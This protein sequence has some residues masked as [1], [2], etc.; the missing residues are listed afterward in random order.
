MGEPRT[1]DQLA[2]GF[3]EIE[4]WADRTRARRWT[5]AGRLSL[6]FY[7]LMRRLR[8]AILV[9]VGCGVLLLSSGTAPARVGGGA[10][11]T[12][13][14]RAAAAGSAAFTADVVGEVGASGQDG[15][16]NSTC[17]LDAD[18]IVPATG[19]FPNS[20]DGRVQS[21]VAVSVTTSVNTAFPGCSQSGA[22]GPWHGQ[23]MEQSR[24]GGPNV[25][26]VT[27]ADFGALASGATVTRTLPSFSPAAGAGEFEAV[28]V[29]TGA[30]VQ[31]AQFHFVGEDV[32]PTPDVVARA[33][34]SGDPGTVEVLL[35]VRSSAAGSAACT[36]R[37]R[38]GDRVVPLIRVGTKATGSVRLSD[39]NAVCTDSETV[40]VLSGALTVQRAVRVP[41][42]H[43]A[44]AAAQAVRQSNGTI[45]TT[46]RVD[47]LLPTAKC[48]RPTASVRDSLA[49]FDMPLTQI[50]GPGARTGS[51]TA[52]RSIPPTTAFCISTLGYT[53]T[54]DQATARA[55]RPVTGAPCTLAP[56]TP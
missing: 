36:L 56:K 49:S 20:P 44:F 1:L 16:G 47:G 7:V 11:R 33:E 50:S 17:T 42:D 48:G 23:W 24:N 27:L 52:V 55:E 38:V 43:L 4:H 40:H 29:W 30:D 54:Q 35:S 39:R 10:G 26:N 15:C 34:R 25:P 19:R 13:H 14:G 21:G 9:L 41:G 37:A 6:C 12:V 3:G 32:C 46:A 28:W 53:V 31:C 8:L 18:Q 5:P 2:C 22:Q 45:V 51:A